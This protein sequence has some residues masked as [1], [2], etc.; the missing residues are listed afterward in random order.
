MSGAAQYSEDQSESR[1]WCSGGGGDTVQKAVVQ[2]PQLCQDW[3]LTHTAYIL[4][5]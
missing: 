4:T 5:A 2:D 3:S 1:Q